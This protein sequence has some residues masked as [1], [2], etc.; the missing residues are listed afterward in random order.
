MAYINITGDSD[1]DLHDAAMHNNKFG[2]IASVLNGNINADNLANP[3]GI[4]TM[5]FSGGPGEQPV[6]NV[7]SESWVSI[8]GL[9]SATVDSNTHSNANGDHQCLFPSWVK[10]NNASDI[11]SCHLTYLASNAAPSTGPPAYTAYLQSAGTLTGT[12]STTH[13]TSG[14][15]NWYNASPLMREDAFTVNSAGINAGRY[16]RMVIVN[17]GANSFYPPKMTLTLTLKTRHV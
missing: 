12:Y 2:A 6:A 10:V 13:C 5:T 9:T 15:L 16:I 17:P 7:L 11:V 14:T 4:Y 8:A 1:G 3:D